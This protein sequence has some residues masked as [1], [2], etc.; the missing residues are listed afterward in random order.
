VCVCVYVCVCVCVCGERQRKRERERWEVKELDHEVLY[1]S[2]RF[3]AQ[4]LLKAVFCFYFCG[5]GP[6]AL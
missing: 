1:I 5:T 4:V 3:S 2:A 6:H